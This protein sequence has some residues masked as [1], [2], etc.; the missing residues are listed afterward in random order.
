MI[1]KIIVMLIDE[2]VKMSNDPTHSGEFRQDVNDAIQ[3]LKKIK[4]YF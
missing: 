3:A 2:L 1:F 4:V